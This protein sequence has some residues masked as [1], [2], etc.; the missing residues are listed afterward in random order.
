[1]Q[2]GPLDA[3]ALE[4]QVAHRLEE[5]ILLGIAGGTIRHLEE[6][7]VGIVEQHLKRLPQ[8]QCRLV[9]HLGQGHRQP[10][11]RRGWRWLG[12]PLVQRHYLSVGLHHEPPAGRALPKGSSDRNRTWGV[13]HNVNSLASKI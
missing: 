2:E 6:R 5:G 11:C 1:M 7:V 13:I 10:C 8:L 12:I 9:A 4:A 3:L